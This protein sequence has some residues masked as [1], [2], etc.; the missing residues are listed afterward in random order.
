MNLRCLKC[1][2]DHPTKESEIKEKQDNPYCIN[3]EVYEHT[4]CYTKCPRIPKPKKE[5]PIS[6]RNN[7]NFTSN[8][9]VDGIPFANLLAEK[10]ESK[11]PSL[12]PSDNKNNLERQSTSQ[13]SPFHEY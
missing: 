6:N 10:I 4:A 3:C 9:V 12:H 13:N 2:K 8:H 5:T 11:D 7:R 1:R